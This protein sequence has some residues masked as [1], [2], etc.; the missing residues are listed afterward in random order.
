L[1]H[2]LVINN[3]AVID[4][5][6]LDFKTGMTVLT[7][8]TGA[9][10]SILLDALGLILGNRADTNIIRGGSDKTDITAIFSIN[11][12]SS[13][14]TRLKKMEIEAD[15]ELFI[16]RTISKDGR[17][18]AYLN[19]TPVPVQTLRDIGEHL[20][21][22]HG[23]HAHQSLSKA[24]MQRELLD[25]FGQ[26]DS[27]LNKVMTIFNEW[28]QVNE[29]LL[30]FKTD[31]EDYEARLT[32]L[33]YQ[34]DELEQLAIGETEYVDLSEQYKRQS[35]SQRLLETC[36]KI[37]N[38]LSESESA[39]NDRLS[40]HQKE[41]SELCAFD[42]SLENISTLVDSATI[43]IEEASH[44]LKSYIERFEY[45]ED[46]LST[47]EN[48]L[49][50]LH[51]LARKHKV[52]PEELPAHLKLLSMQLEQLEGGQEKHESLLE[53]KTEL[54]NDFF[55][56]AK[57]LTKKRTDA[58][59]K[60]SKSVTEKMHELGLAGKFDIDINS[61]NDQTPHQTGMDNISFIVSTNPGQPLRPITKVASGGELSRLSLAIQIIGA[62]DKGI[63]TLIFDEVDAGI[64]GGI[65]EVVGKMLHSLAEH[66]QIFCVTHLAQV[67]SC[68][69]HHFRVAKESEGN[70]TFTRVFD[71]NKQERIDEI[72]RI[73][74]GM[75]VTTESRANAANMLES[76]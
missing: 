72:A 23:Q 34:I 45:N 49:D 62:K 60:F 7:G 58:A 43:Q 18:R 38:D 41:I 71:L 42:N 32:L 14:A 28:K 75:E 53:K 16:R 44:E 74:A 20:I 68:G 55:K 26:Y 9:G 19:N 39:I 5:L 35:H 40:Q 21:D 56:A 69:H 13:V 61:I 24:K 33:K 51:E 73:L 25:Q 3:L 57:Q 10:K 4:S 59:Q 31:G 15:G 48:R 67:A 46:Q 6:N 22:I 66:R 11:H 29:Q 63:P 76:V 64:S 36:Q 30:D 2:Q 54:T 65:A 1:L 17:S 12:D 70:E 37:Y 52:K 8:E 27:L 50:K 47:I